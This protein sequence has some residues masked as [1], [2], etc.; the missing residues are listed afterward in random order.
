[1][2]RIE[3]RPTAGEWVWVARARNVAKVPSRR[4]SSPDEA[5]RDLLESRQPEEDDPP[6]AVA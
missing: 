6:P 5:L 4:F 3:L 2:T 1:M